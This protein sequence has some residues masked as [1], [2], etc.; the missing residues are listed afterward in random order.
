MA[1]Y[2]VTFISVQQ[3]FRSQ[4]N[5]IFMN[6]NP[7]ADDLLEVTL[8]WLPDAP[9]TLI[10]GGSDMGASRTTY[11]FSLS[12]KPGDLANQDSIAVAPV[13]ADEWD[14]YIYDSKQGLI[15]YCLSKGG[16][17]LNAGQACSFTL[18]K[19]GA[20]TKGTTSAAIPFSFNT[21]LVL[22][23]QPPDLSHLPFPITFE[24][25][26]KEQ[27]SSPSPPLAVGF[28]TTNMV[29]CDGT[30][31]NAL[32]LRIANQGQTDIALGT[33]Q[34]SITLSFDAGSDTS[35]L[36]ELATPNQVGAFFLP[37]KLDSSGVDTG[38][39]GNSAWNIAKQEGNPPTWK[40]TP[41]PAYTALPVDAA[42]EIPISNIVT[43]H[44]TGR[45]LM[46]VQV[47]GLT[48]YSDQTF[49][50][51]IQKTPLFY[52]NGK[53]GIGTTSPSTA[54]TVNGSGTISGKLVIGSMSAPTDP[55]KIFTGNQSTGW[56]H[57]D[58]TVN[59]LTYI[60]D[61]LGAGL[62]T[63]S[64][65]PLHFFTNAN[66][67]APQLTLTTDG[68]L[69][70]GTKSPSAALDVQGNGAISGKLGIGTTNPTNPLDIVTGKNAIGMSHSGGSVG[71]YTFVDEARGALLGTYTNH[72]LHL[73]T[74]FA[75][76]Q[77]TLTTEGKVGIGTESPAE[78]L[79]VKGNLQ[80]D[81]GI[82]INGQP[83]MQLQAYVAD[84]KDSNG[85]SSIDTGY[86]CNDWVAIIGGFKLFNPSVVAAEAVAYECNNTWWILCGLDRDP[87][88]NYAQDT[89]TPSV[90][91]L[92]I[93]RELVNVISTVSGDS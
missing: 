7:T 27:G 41:T 76:P 21:K 28:D 89:R 37:G 31:Q 49:A 36:W 1:N 42:V 81:G 78:T 19:V 8:D 51:E 64:N 6:D 58:G 77:L 17:I 29:L 91:V 4:P 47:Q 32:V 83:A 80:V 25:F 63:F 18:Q 24:P 72:S 13:S 2:N 82:K 75:N 40:L 12:F 66:F 46:H 60:D 68:K 3:S 85:M 93:R 52:M 10:L 74:H 62:G 35:H 57:D 53:V 56:S 55:L 23:A 33:A 14:I 48:G 65:H 39:P 20:K 50:V 44:A 15:I 88:S 22:N 86:S 34:T 54:L 71:F 84:H 90:A 30:S 5:V 43:G 16:L 92:F 26:T 87:N 38:W 9:S 61:A 45:A 67:N 73:R 79:H 70:I 69:G 59:L 11:D